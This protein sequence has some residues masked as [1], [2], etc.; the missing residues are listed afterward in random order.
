VNR[1][2][3]SVIPRG[4]IRC[5]GD[6]F[7]HEVMAMDERNSQ[8]N[9]LGQFLPGNKGGPGNPAAAAVAR[10]RQALLEAVSVSELREVVRS[11]LEQALAG[12]IQ[13]A[14]LILERCC[15]R[16]EPSTT[17]PTVAI[18]NVM[19]SGQGERSGQVLARDIVARITAERA[20]RL[21]E[22]SGD[23]S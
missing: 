22:V 6:R 4:I 2:H 7:S 11:V 10:N 23:Q 21:I 20:G 9:A 14:K 15:G 17:A 13:A 18:Q 3:P 5:P 19:N 16:A 8:R 1:R 12:D